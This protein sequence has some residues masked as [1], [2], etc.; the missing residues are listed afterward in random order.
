VFASIC[1]SDY[2]SGWRVKNA[3]DC[4][5]SAFVVETH[6]RKWL[7]TNSH[8]VSNASFVQ[9]RRFGAAKKHTATV[10]YNS[11]ECD[12]AVLDVADAEFWQDIGSFVI[13]RELPRLQEEVNVIGFPTGGDGVSTTRGVVSRIDQVNYV[14]G[15]LARL[16]SLQ[17]DAAINP[18]NSGGPCV[19]AQNELVG[20]AFQGLDHAENIGYLIPSEILLHFFTDITR[21]ERFVGFPSLGIFTQNLD[22][23]DHR[24]FLRMPPGLTGVLI[25]RVGSCGSSFGVLQPDDVLL[26]VAGRQVSCDGTVQLR[27]KGERVHFEVVVQSFFAG[28]KIQL[29]IWRDGREEAKEVVGMPENPLC[30]ATRALPPQYVVFG[31]LVFVS[32][33]YP[34]FADSYTAGEIEQGNETNNELRL[35][36]KCDALRERPRQEVVLLSRVLSDDCNQGYDVLRHHELRSV[37]DVPV[38]NLRHLVSLLDAPEPPFFRFVFKGSRCIVMNA[39]KARE[40][41]PEILSRHKIAVPFSLNSSDEPAAT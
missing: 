29:S 8:V 21:H 35:F 16:L 30:P 15:R 38:E 32:L 34:Y 2:F 36:I 18:G 33:S 28:D 9:V 40:R 4:T 10:R 7:V 26:A 19:N 39:A 20:V 11:H 27:G 13:Q 25:T 23:P 22:N 24:G 12:L 41:A 5:G 6:G 31:G 1:D 3:A 14:Q 37:N 17:I